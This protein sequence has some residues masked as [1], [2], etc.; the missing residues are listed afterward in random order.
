[1]TRSI[2]YQDGRNIHRIAP[3]LSARGNGEIK[4]PKHVE[5]T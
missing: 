4:V 2:S 5:A 1:M 3:R